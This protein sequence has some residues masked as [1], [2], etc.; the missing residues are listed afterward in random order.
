MAEFTN[1]GRLDVLVDKTLVVELAQRSNAGQSTQKVRPRSW[2]T[3]HG[4]ESIWPGI[5][6]GALIGVPSYWTHGRYNRTVPRPARDN[7]LDC[8]GTSFR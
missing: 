6:V 4:R 1:L 8:S 5:A 3:S 7:R 2:V